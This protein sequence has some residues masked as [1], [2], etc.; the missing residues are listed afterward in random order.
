MLTPRLPI[1]F[2]LLS[3]ALLIGCAEEAVSPQ[4]PIPPLPEIAIAYPPDGAVI[5]DSVV[6]WVNA[7]D[8]GVIPMLEYY[9][10]DYLFAVHDNVLAA[11]SAVWHPE[12]AELGSRHV[13]TARAVSADSLSFELA[14][15]IEIYYQWELLAADSN[16]SDGVNLKRVFARNSDA[17]LEFR[18]ET[19]GTWASAHSWG[20]LDCALFWDT[21][22]DSSTGLTVDDTIW[23]TVNDLGPDFAALLGAEGDSLMYWDEGRDRWTGLAGIEALSLTDST[24]YLEFGIAITAIGSPEEINIVAANLDGSASATLTDWAPDAGHISYRLDG[25]YI[26]PPIPSSGEGMHRF[27]TS[28]TPRTLTWRADRTNGRN[29]K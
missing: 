16:E 29:P 8:D 13:L 18:I 19:Y 3:A 10:D 20:G 7:L 12:D 14:D 5:G 4:A 15:S 2:V 17:A 28:G 22:L 27:T 9:V 25:T 24:D 26:G 11:D 23:Y 1:S 21:D 6:V